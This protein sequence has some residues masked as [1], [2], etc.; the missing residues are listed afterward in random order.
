[1]GKSYKTIEEIHDAYLRGKEKARIV[2]NRRNE[3]IKTTG[4]LPYSFTYKIRNAFIGKEC[5]I[6]GIRMGVPVCD[7]DES[8][9]YV[10]PYP[11]IQHN[12]PLAK[13]GTHTIDNISVICR[14]CNST[15][16]DNITGDLNNQEVREV[17]KRINEL[18]QT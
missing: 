5:P 16:K 11:S 4:D 1:M 6:C 8:F 3:R 13:G 7:E 17:W 2:A 10:A 9:S 12:I 15:I 14:S 18:Y